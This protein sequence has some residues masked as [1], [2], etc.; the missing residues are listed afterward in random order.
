MLIKIYICTIIFT[1]LASIPYIEINK[2]K[3]VTIT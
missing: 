2:R 3:E 1:F